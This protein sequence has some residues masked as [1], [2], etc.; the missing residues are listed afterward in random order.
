MHQNCWMCHGTY[1]NRHMLWGFPCNVHSIKCA[2]IPSSSQ[3]HLQQKK[4]P[5]SALCPLQALYSLSF[6]M[7]LLMVSACPLTTDMGSEPAGAS[8][9]SFILHANPA[10]RWCTPILGVGRRRSAQA[11]DEATGPNEET[12]GEVENGLATGSMHTSLSYSLL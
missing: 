10:F 8:F 11:A 2:G 1:A 5:S 6:S 3:D 4:S 9:T 12:G 7:N